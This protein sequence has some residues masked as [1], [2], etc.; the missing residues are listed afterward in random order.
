[1]TF[2]IVVVGAGRHGRGSADILES[3]GLSVAG[4]VD[5]TRPKGEM[6]S[7]FPVL[8]GFAQMRDP[9]FVRD[10]SWFVAIGDNETRK[11][12]CRA[13]ADAGANFANVVHPL[14]SVSR[15]ATLGRGL[16]FGA[17]TTVQTGAH[18]GDWVLFGAHVYVGV[19]GRI[20]EAAFIGHGVIIS[21]GTSI[22]A[23]TFLGSGVTL[24]NNASVGIDC[25]VGANSLVMR[26]M[27]D[28]TTAY[29][30]PARP[31]PLKRKPFKS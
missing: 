25:V 24:S 7:G 8:G 5:D 13:L 27:P 6:V 14:A 30:V 12:L 3:Q 23:G 11:N 21:A 26:S 4:Y 17:C 28:D 9:A 15:R 22:G 18:I 1:M 10:H 20:G 29:G 31:A 16:Y 2:P 19:D